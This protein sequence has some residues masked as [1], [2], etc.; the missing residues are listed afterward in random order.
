MYPSLRAATSPKLR[1][2]AHAVPHQVFVPPRR[3][4]RKFGEATV[5]RAVYSRGVVLSA[6]YTSLFIPESER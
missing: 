6:G 4:L 1:F 3:E 2:H 5:R